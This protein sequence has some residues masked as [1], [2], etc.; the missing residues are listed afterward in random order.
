[1][2]SKSSDVPALFA[3]AAFFFSFGLLAILRPATVR[4]AVGT[5]ADARKR[6][7]WH[8]YKMPLHL[9]RLIV[10]GTGMLGAA[11]F[12]YIAVTILKR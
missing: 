9:L 4:N 7:S 3:M 12:V 8:P 5:L 11:L 6:G 10:G 2:V 1:M